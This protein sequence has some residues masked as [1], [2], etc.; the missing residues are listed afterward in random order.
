MISKFYC[1]VFCHINSLGDKISNT[2]ATK[3]PNLFG[4]GKIV[5]I[6]QRAQRAGIALKTKYSP[7]VDIT[8]RLQVR[9]GEVIHKV[10]TSMKLSTTR[11]FLEFFTKI[12]QE[13]NARNLIM[14]QSKI[15]SEKPAY[16]AYRNCKQD[17]STTSN[18]ENKIAIKLRY[19]SNVP[20]ISKIF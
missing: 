12:C 18:Y 16:A 7:L 4:F 14:I 19:S 3:Q 10:T 20:Q 17:R 15:S 5:Y 13:S 2:A 9:N 8:D 6:H 11:Y 1:R